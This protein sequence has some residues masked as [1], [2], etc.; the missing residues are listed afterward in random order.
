MKLVL[1]AM[2]NKQWAALGLVVLVASAS[3]GSADARS[4]RRSSSKTSYKQKSGR[5]PASQKAAARRALSALEELD[6]WIK[7]Y[8][9]PSVAEFKQRSA[10]TAYIVNQN[11][12]VLPNGTVKTKL[13]KA[14]DGFRAVAAIAEMTAGF[15]ESD[16]TRKIERQMAELLASTRQNIQD[17]KKELVKR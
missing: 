15:S 3:S 11:V 9:S 8:P 12:A 14:G 2:M 5:W 7:Y 13:K 16:A 4:R 10:D 17:A 6:K 1:K